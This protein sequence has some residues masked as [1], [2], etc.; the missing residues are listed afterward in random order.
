MPLFDRVINE[1]KWESSISIA[2][3]FTL[4]SLN[5]A[6]CV[7][8]ALSLAFKKAACESRSGSL[9]IRNRKWLTSWS[10]PLTWDQYD[11]LKLSLKVWTACQAEEHLYRF[12]CLRWRTKLFAAPFWPTSLYSCGMR[13][14]VFEQ[15]TTDSKCYTC[16]SRLLEWLSKSSLRPRQRGSCTTKSY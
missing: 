6:S 7:K 10:L 16:P 5:C 15:R 9:C 1:S 12:Q 4:C 11:E 3:V 8:E 13:L 14:K 2:S